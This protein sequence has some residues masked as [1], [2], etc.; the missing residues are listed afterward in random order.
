MEFLKNFF[1]I[2]LL[3]GLVAP[4][5]AKPLD[6]QD[7]YGINGAAQ[8]TQLIQSTQSIPDIIGNVI[9]IALSF[10]GVV[11][12]LLVLFGGFRW[13]TA[14][15]NEEKVTS[16]KSIMEHAAIG[17][18]IVL[19]AY[20]I[21]QFVFGALNQ[22]GSGQS[23]SNSTAPSTTALGCCYVTSPDV[24]DPQGQLRPGSCEPLRETEVDCLSIP[25]LFTDATVRWRE[26]ECLASCPVS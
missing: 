1:L 8:G 14:F 7:P 21:A 16:A 2:I 25:D 10:V 22:A 4:V 24:I 5:S 17:L 26:G 6:P 3:V 12:F 19:A 23:T 13:M 18:V 11:F 15:G 20:A 9:G